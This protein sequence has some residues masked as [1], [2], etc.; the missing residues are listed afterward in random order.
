M[1]LKYL[2]FTML[3]ALSLTAGAAQKIKCSIPVTKKA[4][5]AEL[6]AL[7]TVSRE[8][9]ETIA[10]ATLTRK[11]LAMTSAEL[12]VEKGCLVWSFD[13]KRAEKPGFT[14]IMV[15]AGNGKV[16]SQR[17]ESPQKEAAERANRR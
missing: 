4:T 17:Y 3:L 6:K 1:P 8:D 5:A 7:A 11:P 14:E 16:V 10:R 12:E 2:L 13:F 9:A 15:D